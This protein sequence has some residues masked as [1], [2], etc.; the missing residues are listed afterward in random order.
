MCIYRVGDYIAVPFGKDIL[1]A[2]VRN[3]INFPSL[4]H[5]ALGVVMKLMV[6]WWIT[7]P[8]VREI[9]DGN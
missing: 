4:F 7:E 9:F 6:W 5:G 1:P 2:V 3:I 8:Y